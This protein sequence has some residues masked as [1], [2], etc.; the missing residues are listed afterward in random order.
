MWH[1]QRT[2]VL[3]DVI[4]LAAHKVDRAPKQAVLEGEASD[5]EESES[6]SDSIRM[7]LLLH[8]WLD[9]EQYELLQVAYATVGKNF[10]GQEDLIGSEYSK[11]QKLEMVPERWPLARLSFSLQTCVDHLDR[12]LAGCWEVQATRTTPPESVL[13]LHQVAK[14][15]TIKLAVYLP[16]RL[17]RFSGRFWHMRPRSCT[18]TVRCICYAPI[19]GYRR[20]TRNCYIYRP[21]MPGLGVLVMLIPYRS[22]SRPTGPKWCSVVT[23]S[24]LKMNKLNVIIWVWLF[25]CSPHATT[26]HNICYMKPAR[27]LLT[28]HDM[29]HVMD[30]LPRLLHQNK[31]IFFVDALPWQLYFIHHHL[32]KFHMGMHLG[33]QIMFHDIWMKSSAH[34][35]TLSSLNKDASGEGNSREIFQTLNPKP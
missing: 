28:W 23:Q 32:M 25:A 29:Q 18:M 3:A 33:K 1:G 20:F 31:P 14:C 8:L 24:S 2:Q 12:V 22:G 11:L 4:E 34:L 26:W 21:D 6:A 10:T 9:A 27:Q 35:T 13:S 17:L 16:K 7:I 30:A 15:L 19:I 5:S